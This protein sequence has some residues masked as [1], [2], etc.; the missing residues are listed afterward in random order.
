MGSGAGRAAPRPPISGW[1]EKANAGN[2][3]ILALDTPSVLNITTG[4]PSDPCFTPPCTK[5]RNFRQE[6]YETVIKYNH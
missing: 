6:N 5:K 4:D 1:I 2:T 3:A